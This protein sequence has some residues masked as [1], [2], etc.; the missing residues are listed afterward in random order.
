[1]KK[2]L[3][4][5]AI[6]AACT[7][8]FGQDVHF[9]N[10][11]ETPLL[12]N[13]ALSAADNNTRSIINY[14]NQWNSVQSPFK[15][16]NFSF[17]MKLDQKQWTKVKGKTE[18]YKLSLKNLCAGLNIVQDK[19]GDSKMGLTQVNL[20]LASHIFLNQ[21][22]RLSAGFFFGMAQRN[23][24]YS[25]LQFQNQY[26]GYSYN[27]SAPSGENFGSGNFTYGDAGAGINWTLLKGNI[28]ASANNGMRVSAGYACYHVNRP[29]QSF[30]GNSSEKL[31]RK[32][33]F[34]ANGVFGIKNTTLS[35]APSVNY[36]LQGASQEIMLG[37]AL[38]FRLKE[39]SK[40]T[41]FVKGSQFSIG[42]FY[43]NKDAVIVSAMLETGQFS[44]GFNY[45]INVSTLKNYSH[46]NG[47]FEISLR[48]ITPNP[49]VFEPSSRF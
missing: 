44:F 25:N 19:A 48:F 38:K 17:E 34:Y 31:F 30:F 29:K 13:P 1:M 41:G 21:A 40:I 24:D 16:F 27:A 10:P 6:H 14:R 7:F 32:H 28:Y 37:A 9:S 23:I 15:T 3:F 33:N 47:A 46:Y 8:S 49:F 35:F 36:S 26:N 12:L 18:A 45:D 39:E 4:S 11:N 2:T 43:R 42:A 20:S 22:N 5:L